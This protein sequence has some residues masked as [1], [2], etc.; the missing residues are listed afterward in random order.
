[1]QV[2]RYDVLL[3]FELDGSADILLHILQLVRQGFHVLVYLLG[4]DFGANLGNFYVRVSQKAAQRFNGYAVRQKHGRGVRVACDMVGQTYLEAA[5]SACIFEYLVAASVTRNGENMTVPSQP[6]VLL[7]DTLGNIQKADVRFGV[8]LLSSCD[9]PH[10]AV[11]ECLQAVGGEVLHVRIRQI[12]EHGKNEQV[13]YKLMGGV[14]HGC[15]H[16]RLYLR[17]GEVTPI[18]VFGRVDISGKEIKG[19][20]PVVPRNG[21]DVL[22]YNHVT[23]HGI[24]AAFLLRVQNILEIVDEC[25]VEFILRNIHCRHGIETPE[26]GCRPS[27]NG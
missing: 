7:D 25:E 20:T 13:P 23:P 10:V 9:Y 26:Y 27:D 15:V 2:S 18:H 1:M 4:G 3:C 24:G 19:Q 14:I 21:N 22:Q 16:K 6:L 8:G 17:F 5:L 12:R 11:E